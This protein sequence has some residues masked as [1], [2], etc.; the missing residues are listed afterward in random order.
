[1]KRL[2]FKQRTLSLSKV[3]KILALTTIIRLAFAQEH[4]SG[5]SSCPCLSNFTT[6]FGNETRIEI[7]L[8]SA[9]FGSNYPRTFG[10]GCK[11]HSR[12]TTACT[13]IIE[14]CQAYHDVSPP[15]INCDF[16][17][18]NRSWCYVDP[19]NC[20]LL[21]RPVFSSSNSSVDVQLSYSYATCGDMDAFTGSNRY[22]ALY[23][24]RLRAGINSNSG[25]W[26][27]VFADDKKHFT[28]PTSK[29]SGPLFNFI[30]ESARLGGY[31]FVITE[32][33]THLRDDADR[34]SNGTDFDFCIYAASLGYVDLCIAQ[35]T[36][37]E[38]RSNM[39][40]WFKL[41]TDD[42]YLFVMDESYFD[43]TFESMGHSIGTIFTPFT[44]QT[45]FFII[46]L[47]IPVL[48]CLMIFHERGETGSSF[49]REETVLI[50]LRNGTV[51]PRTRKIPFARTIIKAFYV[52]LLAV[53]QA[54]YE[55]SVV[56]VGAMLNLLGISFFI[57]T[58]IA[59]YTA[60]LAAIL[61]QRDKRTSI[62][63]LDDV[64]VSG[65]RICVERK[66]MDAVNVM[67]QHVNPKL[68]FVRDPTELGGDGEPGFACKDCAAR[69]RTFDFVDPRQAKSNPTYCHAAIAPLEDL[70]FLQGFGL[71]CNKTLVG[72]P[73]RSLMLGFPIFQQQNPVLSSHFL[74]VSS[75]NIFDKL[76]LEGR[77]PPQCKNYNSDSGS[78]L[79]LSQLSGIW[80]V[81]FGFA[82]AGVIYTSVERFYEKRFAKR[83]HKVQQLV[84][85]DQRGARITI[86]AAE[87]SPH[88]WRAEKSI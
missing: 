81:C 68:N 25:G 37:N 42:L 31:E 72:K 77:P 22:S 16:S 51:Y 9:F 21:N 7:N 71:H 67:Y 12:I 29:W 82:I 15:P 23:G 28:G 5:D 24:T 52:T 58:I 19:N 61:S 74:S 18:C 75:M 46:V 70:E 65:M 8:D 57:L 30:T 27:G 2:C 48:A 20:N 34:Y 80:V 4:G 17:W 38:R 54:S 10:L 32:L 3:V 33:P 47:V 36:I 66:N 26:K 49:P 41:N 50:E 44:W 39:T 64:R 11:S 59:V 76:I 85:R 87:H 83:K 86:H 78:S 79:S 43:S 6:I 84:K 53:L 45:W 88:S 14:R 55:Q 63:D 1:M 35:Y 60:N 13:A 56:T 73:I 69:I 62:N 40:E